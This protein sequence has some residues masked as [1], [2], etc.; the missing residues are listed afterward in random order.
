MKIMSVVAVCVSLR[1]GCVLQTEEDG[2]NT[3][4]TYARICV[5]TVCGHDY[6][7]ATVCGGV[8]VVHAASCPCMSGGGHGEGGA[9]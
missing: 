4:D 3:Q 5:K 9:E 6:V 7:V 1:G 8:S 2:T